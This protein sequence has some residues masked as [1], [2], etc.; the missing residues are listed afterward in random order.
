[1]PVGGRCV[2]ASGF[3]VRVSRLR[4]LASFFMITV[5][6]MMSGLLV[7]MCRGVMV[8]RSLVMM[9]GRSMFRRLCHKTFF[10]QLFLSQLLVSHAP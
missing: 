4:M 9:F 5:L 2:L 8:R 6:M 3:A 1:M 10:P 7:M